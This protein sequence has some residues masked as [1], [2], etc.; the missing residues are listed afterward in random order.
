ME[1]K[2][3]KAV[4]ELDAEF[5]DVE[6]EDMMN[7]RESYSSLAE[8]VDLVDSTSSSTSRN[9]TSSISSSFPASRSVPVEANPNSGASPPEDSV[10]MDLHLLQSWPVRASS[11]IESSTARSAIAA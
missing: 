5:E 9:K 2:K 8:Q 11:F 6:V 3:S 1:L 7:V 4:R 10:D